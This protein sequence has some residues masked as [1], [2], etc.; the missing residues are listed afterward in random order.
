[1]EG[2]NHKKVTTSRGYTYAYYVYKP[3]VTT[4]KPVL[5]LCHGY[6]D[7]ALLWADIV[8]ALKPLGHPI[9]V[10][11]MLGYGGTSK[12]TDPKEYNSKLLAQDLY[13][14]ADAEGFGTIIPT[15]HDWGSFVAARLYMWRPDR[16]AGLILL[17]AAYQPPSGSSF[18]LA[19][20]LDS[21]EKIFGYPTLAYWEFFR[22]DDAAAVIRENLETFFHLLHWDDPE[23]MLK[24]FCVRG[25]L[26]RL[27]IE[28][29]P[30]ELPLKPYAQ[31]PGFKEAFL[32]R[33]GRDGF[34]GP[35]CYYTVVVKN[36]QSASEKE[37]PKENLLVRVPCLYISSTGDTVCRTDLMEPVKH[38]VPDLQVHIVE[39]NHWCPYEKPVEVRGHMANW[40]KSKYPG[41]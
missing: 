21:T 1:M 24:S 27:L 12:P 25:A 28:T 36:F 17:N 22:S 32:E 37:I 23:A 10:P 31:R 9:I 30:E 5:F 39:G 7:E 18:D 3:T 26:R 41:S 8:P 14:T 4:T 20:V 19:A 13:E 6:P 40:L 15:G 29:K 38:L 11:D 33:F 35:L 34:E 2:F 16:C